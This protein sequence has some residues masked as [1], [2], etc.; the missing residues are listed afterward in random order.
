[1]KIYHTELGELPFLH[2]L[3]AIKALVTIQS[4]FDF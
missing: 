2:N 3:D 1:M 4:D